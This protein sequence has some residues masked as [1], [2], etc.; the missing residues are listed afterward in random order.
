MTAIPPCQTQRF[1]PSDQN[2]YQE[3]LPDRPPR[4][5]VGAPRFYSR[6]FDSSIKSLIDAPPAA[7]NPPIAGKRL[8]DSRLLET[9]RSMKVNLRSALR[10]PLDGRPPPRHR[11]PPA[12]PAAP[13]PPGPRYP[14]HR[15]Y[16][17]SGYK[18]RTPTQFQQSEVRQK[19]STAHLTRANTSAKS[20]TLTCSRRRSIGFRMDWLRPRLRDLPLVRAA[21]G[22][23]A[24]HRAQHHAGL[25]DD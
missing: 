25:C 12:P 23:R 4:P 2:L 18:T 3:R 11:P 13:A 8:P 14:G 22:R 16:R 10:L 17:F 15:W 20:A 6:C 7:S 21:R 9:A 24:Q 1:Y 5:R 19:A